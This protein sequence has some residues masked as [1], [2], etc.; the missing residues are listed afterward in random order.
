[1]TDLNPCIIGISQKTWR[2]EEGDAPHPALQCIERSL[3]ALANTGANDIVGRI[4][5]INIVYP[6]SWSYDDLAAEVKSGI[7]NPDCDVRVSGLSGTSPQK[8]V[9]E[10]AESI[11]SGKRNLVLVCGAEA[12]ATRKRAKKENRDTGWPRGEKKGMPP[13]EDPFHPA[14]INHQVFQAYTTFATLDSARRALTDLAPEKY[15]KEEARMMAT[16]SKVAANNPHAWFREERNSDDLFNLEGNDRLVAYP[17]S[18]NTMAFMD[19]DMSAALVIASDQLA[20]ELDVPQNQRIYINGWGYAK[21]IP[22]IAQRDQ[23]GE[24]KA[25]KTASQQ[26]LQRAGI[27]IDQIKLLDLYSCFASNLNFTCDALGI[28]TDDP[29]GL[30]ITGGLPYFGGPGNNYT[31]HSIAS[32]VD[33]LRNAPGEYGMISAVGMHMTNH[34]F[35]VYSTNNTEIIPAEAATKYTAS[36]QLLETA[37]GPA[38]LIACTVEHQRDGISIL[39]VCEME[40]GDRCYARST[41]EALANLLEQEECIGKT[42]TLTTNK[43]ICRFSLK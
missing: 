42:V 21:D 40:N 32:M 17:F 8:F 25:M 28:S 2:E 35:G 31:S 41:D 19:V 13:F 9:N 11:L 7:D 27:T 37:S 5:E 18:K 10:A 22:Y 26:A 14:E 12:F 30:T 39:A 6:I 38:T 36:H 15:R 34:A 24:S 3:E 4:D 23:L 43:K 29:R 1:M 33:Q 16:L 20:N